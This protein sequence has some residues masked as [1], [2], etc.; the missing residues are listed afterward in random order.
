LLF[1]GARI[2]VIGPAVS[3]E[4]E[5]ADVDFSDFDL[6]IKMNRS[7]ETPV[8]HRGAPSYFHNVYFRNQQRSDSPLAGRITAANLRRA[9]VKTI[10]FFVHHWREYPRL[11]RKLLRLRRMRLGIATHVLGPAVLATIGRPIAPHKPTA[12]FILLALLLAQDFARLHIVGFTFFQ[13][14]YVPGYNDRVAEDA[15]ALAWATRNGK[16]SPEA[17]RLAMR[18]MLAARPG[19]DIVL[20]A[21]LAEVLRG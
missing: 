21:K 17:E 9:G 16:H 10:F 2:L 4:A 5:L 12:G 14:R 8:M 6:V 20:G 7:L 13:T 19:A 18:K 3:A 11:W 1:S 15:Q